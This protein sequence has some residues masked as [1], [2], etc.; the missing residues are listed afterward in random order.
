M[1]LRGYAHY[2][3]GLDTK[4]NETGKFTSATLHN[5]YD[6]MFTIGLL[7]PNDETNS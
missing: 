4:F 1:Q 5:D 3:G 6:V 2:P 7:L